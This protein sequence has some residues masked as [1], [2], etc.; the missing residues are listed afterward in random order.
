M[1]WLDSPRWR[2]G[3]PVAHLGH[4]DTDQSPGIAE[5]Y[6][7]SPSQFAG[8]F[9]F[10]RAS[11]LYQLRQKSADLISISKG[12]LI[13]ADP[14]W[15]V[16]ANIVNSNQ[17][18]F[19]ASA[20]TTL[21]TVLPNPAKPLALIQFEIKSTATP[22]TSVPLTFVPITKMAAQNGDALP[23]RWTHGN[24]KIGT[25]N[26]PIN[27]SLNPNNVSSGAAAPRTF[28]AIYSD[29]N[30]ATDIADARILISPNGSGNNALL[31]RYDRSTNKLYL[32]NDS[33]TGFT[34]GFAPGSNNSISN[35]Q[36]TLNCAATTASISGNTL[37][38]N[39]SFTP[40]TG[41]VGNKALFLYVRDTTNLFDGWDH[42][43]TWNITS[44]PSNLSLA[45]ASGSSAVSTPRTL[46]ARYGDPNGATDIADARILISG[47]GA[48]NNALYAR[49]DRATNRLYLANNNVTGFM[50]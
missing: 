32:M 6:S 2:N 45:P 43:G 26:A 14:D 22:D 49:Y 46:T 5:S 47:N 30:G 28:T 19:I 3:K 39:W 48:G 25:S 9:T 16:E 12:S 1:E 41:F 18:R 24:I 37:T 11:S 17:L 13:A 38:I 7:R 21:N 27:V 36:G 40:A 15:A 31:G 10:C 35:S 8:K 33:S 34:G 42:F 20:G 29:P 44:G 50:G 4:F 23:L